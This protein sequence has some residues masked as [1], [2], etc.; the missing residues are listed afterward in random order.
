MRKIKIEKR[1][2]NYG[3]ATDEEVMSVNLQMNAECRVLFLQL[4]N[5]LKRKWRFDH[6]DRGK[7]TLCSFYLSFVIIAF[8]DLKE[9]FYKL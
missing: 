5:L 8:N 4:W 6:I 2:F 7:F 3:N 9:L 1:H